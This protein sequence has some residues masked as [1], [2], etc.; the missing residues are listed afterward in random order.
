MEPVAFL[1]F[2]QRLAQKDLWNSLI[3]HR[4]SKYPAKCVSSFSCRK[5]FKQFTSM[6]IPKAE[7]KGKNSL[8]LHVWRYMNYWKTHGKKR[9]R[10]LSSSKR[11]FFSHQVIE[12]FECEN[13]SSHGFFVRHDIYCRLQSDSTNTKIVPTIF[14]KSLKTHFNWLW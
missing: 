13:G 7:S 8:C 11:L 10:N 1:A 2:S 6:K 5:N 3:F 14:N 4:R 12:K 9:K